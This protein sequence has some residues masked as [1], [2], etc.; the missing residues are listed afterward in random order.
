MKWT[1]EMRE[2]ARQHA[3]KA[4][5]VPTPEEIEAACDA[6]REAWSPE[7]RNSRW[8]CAHSIGNLSDIPSVQRQRNYRKTERH[9]KRVLERSCAEVAA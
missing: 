7:E 4:V 6:I 1:P 2:Q 8:L 5:W 3:V 9:R